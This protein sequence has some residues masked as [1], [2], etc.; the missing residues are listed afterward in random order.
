VT[1][2]TEKNSIRMIRDDLKIKIFWGEERGG[3]L[4]STFFRDAMRVSLLRV[5]HLIFAIFR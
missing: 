2:W 5:S 4:G 3:R 1:Y